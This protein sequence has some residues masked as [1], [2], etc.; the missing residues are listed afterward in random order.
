RRAWHGDTT[1]ALA[2]ARIDAAPPSPKAIRPEIPAAL[3]AVVVRALD[4][5]PLR[6]YANGSAIATALEPAIGY[7][8]PSSPTIAVPV[9]AAAP[10]AAQIAGA[11]EP[12]ALGV[13]RPGAL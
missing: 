11:A 4:P 5:E 12:A 10:V 8:D 9:P 7:P 1:A 3:D 2:A 6:R 13:A